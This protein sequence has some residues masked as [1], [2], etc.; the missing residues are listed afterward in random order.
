MKLES[1]N[2]NY[3][4]VTENKNVYYILDPKN[5]EEFIYGYNNDLL[6]P[7]IKTLVYRNLTI[8]IKDSLICLN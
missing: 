4:R 6:Y 3:I 2:F 5:I 1:T 8:D 7:N